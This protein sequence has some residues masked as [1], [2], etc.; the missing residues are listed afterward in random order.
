MSEKARLKQWVVDYRD[1]YS[2]GDDLSARETNG[3]TPD[4]DE[5][6][7]YDDEAARLLIEAA[8]IL[9]VRVP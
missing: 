5:Y 4:P 9:G 1:W 6:A 8:I 2:F 3:N 7:N